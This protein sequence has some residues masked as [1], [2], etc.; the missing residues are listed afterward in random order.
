MSSRTEISSELRAG[1][2][3]EDPA[4]KQRNMMKRGKLS[5]ETRGLTSLLAAFVELT[6]RRGEAG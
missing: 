1:K 6:V 2:A 5:G 4:S 3:L